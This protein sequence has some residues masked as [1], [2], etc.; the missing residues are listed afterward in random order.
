MLTAFCVKA[1]V[2]W[3]P[4]VSEWSANTRASD[5]NTLWVPRP[6]LDLPAGLESLTAT[7]HNSVSCKLSA[8]EPKG[9]QERFTLIGGI[10]FCNTNHTVISLL[11]LRDPLSFLRTGTGPEGGSIPRGGVTPVHPDKMTLRLE[12]KGFSDA[13]CCGVLTGDIQEYRSARTVV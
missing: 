5:H 2:N 4:S 7:C 11:W 1:Y 13:Y 10:C 9:S 6:I 12:P 3:L 8:F